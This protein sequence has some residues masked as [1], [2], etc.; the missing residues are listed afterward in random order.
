VGGTVNVGDIAGIAAKRK[1]ERG[2]VGLRPKGGLEGDGT[3]LGISR[4]IRLGWV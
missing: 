3:A 4:D 2:K 1:I